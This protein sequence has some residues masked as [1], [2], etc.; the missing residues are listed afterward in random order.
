MKM[1]NLWM[2]AAILSCGLLTVSCTDKQDNPVAE[3]PVTDQNIVEESDFSDYIDL[4]TFAGDDFFRYA[5]G[6]W[7]DSHPLQK[8]QN[9]NGCLAEQAELAD[10]FLSDVSKGLYYDEIVSRLVSS[11]TP[12]SFEADKALLK[13]KLATI[14][15]ADSKETL[16]Q[17]MAQLI[18]DGYQAPFYF[19]A[20]AF[21]RKVTPALLFPFKAADYLAKESTLTTYADIPAGDAKR[22]FKA[23]IDWVGVLV[24]KEL[25]TRNTIGYH[26]DPL[27]RLAPIAQTRTRGAG[28]SMLQ[29]IADKLGIDG[30][31]LLA[32]EDYA[33]LQKEL[34]SYSLE[35]LKDLLVYLVVD[36]DFRF[37]PAPANASGKQYTAG[38]IVYNLLNIAYSPLSTR[39][40]YIYIDQ[41]VNPESKPVVLKMAEEVRQAFRQRIAN[42][43]WLTPATKQKATEKVDAMI[44][45]IGW[46]DKRDKV[47]EA[48]G[49]QLDAKLSTYQ[50]VLKLFQERTSIFKQG[51]GKTSTD[52]LFAANCF[53]SPAYTANAFYDNNNNIMFITPTNM[54]PPIYDSS[55]S[56]AY[57]YGQLA[58]G[59]IGHEITHGFDSN[60]CQYDKTGIKTDWWTPADKNTFL[61]LQEKM[62]NRYQGVEFWPGYFSDGKR[63][64]AENIADLGGLYVGYDAFINKLRQM[65]VSGEELDRQGREYFR[66]FAYGW[67]EVFNEGWAKD[68]YD[69][70]E[71]SPN[72]MRTNG[73]VYMMDE[74]Y[75]L[76]R[77]TSGKQYVAPENRIEIW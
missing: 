41:K 5:T 68:V 9:R 75:R 10:Q 37:M 35:K 1:H 53:V 59:T 14:Q 57:N 26:H 55:R 65:G 44:F 21:Q 46:P 2:T 33:W 16:Y 18:E 32:D 60:G 49:Q 39:I 63:T 8:G 12:A 23:I 24:E 48:S 74:F 15:A 69:T 67:S 38:D 43:T 76:F 70:N 25:I 77:I 54:V 31:E 66:G 22:I 28:T 6:K 50:N 27:T 52:D 62:I 17:V 40:G 58:G 7:M 13:Q 71:H 64:L 34:E 61:D 30:Q 36:R 47:W 4:N 3:G 72:F 45:C 29:V 42:R 51:I 19:A 11:F 73:T 56:L 20:V